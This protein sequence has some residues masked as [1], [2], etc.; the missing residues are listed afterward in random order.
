LLICESTYGGRKHD[1]VEM[2]ANDLLQVVER[3]LGRGG[4]LIIP[5]FSLGRTQT[6]VYFLHQLIHDGRLKATTIYVDSPLAAAASTV[7]KLH[8]ECFD[9]QTALLVQDDPDVFGESLVRYLRTVEESK[10]INRLDEP[11]IIIAASGMCEAGRIQ[12]HLKH[13]IE[14]PKNTILI[15]GFQAPETLGRRIVEKRPEIRIHDH[16]FKLNAEVA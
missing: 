16:V 3:T 1:G 4:K 8:P 10:S 2:L 12:H 13:N 15:I 9:E 6:I 7:F 11:C 5:A 14:N